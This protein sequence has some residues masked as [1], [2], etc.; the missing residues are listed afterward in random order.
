M[1]SIERLLLV[2]PLMHWRGV[3]CHCDAGNARQNDPLLKRDALRVWGVAVRRV[4]RLALK[5]VVVSAA[6]GIATGSSLLAFPN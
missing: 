4:C 1:R 2:V 6:V 5:I 3:Y